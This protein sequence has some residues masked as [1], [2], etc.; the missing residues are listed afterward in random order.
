MQQLIRRHAAD[1]APR[2]I[3]EISPECGIDGGVSWESRGDVGRT[4]RGPAA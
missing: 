1:R 4:M 3:A 2:R